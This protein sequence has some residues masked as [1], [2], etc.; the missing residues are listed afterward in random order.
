MTSRTLSIAVVF[1][2]VVCSVQSVGRGLTLQQV[3]IPRRPA[4]PLFQSEPGEPRPLQIRF[5]P[6]TAL[7]TVTLSVNDQDGYFIPNLRP[8]NFAAYENGVLRKRVT[9]DVEYAAISMSVLLEGGGQYREINDLLSTELPS[10]TLSLL[11]G[12][13]P[14]DKVAVFSYTNTVRLLAD[15]D[16]PRDRLK[17]LFTRL[18][19][20]AFS[21][22]N[23]YDALVQVLN[24]TQSMPGRRA[25]L[26]ISTGLDSFSHATFND[27]V[28]AAERA[29]TPVYCV[30]LAGLVQ[31]DVVDS[32][33]PVLKIDW[34]GVTDRLKR[35]AKVSNGRTYYRD[36]DIDLP[37]IYDDL[38]DHLRVR[39]V[40]KYT[41]PVTRGGNSTRL[42]RVALVDPRTGRP[43]RITEAQGKAIRALV[44]PEASYTPS[45]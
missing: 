24:R 16:Q 17:A 37:A 45:K 43:L 36:T 7:V 41:S 30:D 26:L 11:N 27:V 1:F 14:D 4:K 35:L 34:N 20:S 23:L 39:Y 13:R 21:E 8:E 9:V 18:Q 31:G 2:S 29:D 28:A 25:L 42:V 3:T 40:I 6:Q 32:R 38:M 15:V 22:A 19:I 10:V 44:S 5:D 12:L 33:S